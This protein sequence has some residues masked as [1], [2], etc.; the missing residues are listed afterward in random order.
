MLLSQ[1]Y[2]NENVPSSEFKVN[3]NFNVEYLL[4][5]CNIN[6]FEFN[7][8]QIVK[9]VI[10]PIVDFVNLNEIDNINILEALK[11]HIKKSNNKIVHGIP[12]LVKFIESIEKR[13]E[14]LKSLEIDSLDQDQQQDAQVVKEEENERLILCQQAEGVRVFRANSASQA[15]LDQTI[16]DKDKLETYYQDQIRDRVVDLVEDDDNDLKMLKGFNNQA[17]SQWA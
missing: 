10:A 3:K 12:K 9:S 17:G 7:K 13:I 6:N 2:I 14:E 1:S 15:Y 5:I 4:N 16:I 11:F 8:V